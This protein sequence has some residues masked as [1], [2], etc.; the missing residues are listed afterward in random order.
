[1]TMDHEKAGL[2]SPRV[3]GLLL[4][5]GHRL[6]SPVPPPGP[7]VGAIRHGAFVTVSGQVPLVDGDVLHRGHVGVDVSIEDAQA[8]AK[9]ALLNAMAHLE[10]AAWS[11]DEVIGFPR[12]AGY[13]AADARFTQHGRVIDAA[14]HLLLELFPDCGL[15]ARIAV[16]VSSL[17]RGVPVEIELSAI[18]RT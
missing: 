15:H 1:M 9:F 13:V 16:G 2:P 6:P 4:T 18:L 17:P 12:L 14:S 10:T 8:C 11:M 7:F 5:L 3:R